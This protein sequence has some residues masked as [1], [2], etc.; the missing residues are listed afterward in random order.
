[1]L[2]NPVFE[3]THTTRSYIHTHSHAHKHTYSNTNTHI[4]TQTRTYIHA[5][6]NQKKRKKENLSQMKLPHFVLSLVGLRSIAGRMRSLE[7]AR[8]QAAARAEEVRFRD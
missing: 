1:M 8:S 7:E 3:H 2:S 6:T 5:I 4:R